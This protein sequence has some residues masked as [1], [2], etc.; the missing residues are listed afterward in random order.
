MGYEL[1]K[2]NAKLWNGIV[3]GNETTVL[4]RGKLND[5]DKHWGMRSALEFR[6]Q[7]RRVES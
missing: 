6:K 5:G 2:G 1:R 4:T 7:L 3:D